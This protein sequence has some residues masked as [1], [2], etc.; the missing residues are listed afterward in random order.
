MTI[1]TIAGRHHMVV[2]TTLFV[3]GVGLNV[4]GFLRHLSEPAAAAV[5]AA[6]LLWLVLESPVTFRRPA[7]PPREIGTL[8][9]YGL[10]RMTVVGCAVLGPWRS[11]WLPATVL[12]AAGVV[13]RLVSMRTLGRGYSHHVVRT[14][15]H[16]IVQTGPYR[17]I[18]HPAYAGML[19]G[20]AG[21]VL[22]FLS[23]AAVVAWFALAAAL[24]WRISTEERELLA[25]PAY[26]DYASGKP[27]LV[28]GMW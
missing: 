16:V 15:D 8:I 4:A 1:M 24:A 27:R 19:L 18:R 17:M 22:C 23:P 25:V 28:P 9:C 26:R 3:I 13:L 14:D 7:A 2:P 12:L 6:N 5:I 20:H 21:L 11:F 10:A